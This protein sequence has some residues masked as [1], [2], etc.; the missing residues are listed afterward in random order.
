MNLRR[1]RRSLL[2]SAIKAQTPVP[3]KRH[4]VVWIA[5]VSWDGICGTDRRLATAMA[6]HAHILWVDPPVSILRSSDRLSA[7]SRSL[8]PT[9]SAVDDQITRLTPTAT[10]GR[11]RVGARTVVA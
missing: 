6:R 9:L 2:P 7:A 5:G 4:V 10:P 1:I 11:N 8:R 3:E